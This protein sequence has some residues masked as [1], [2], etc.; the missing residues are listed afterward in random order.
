MCP[1]ITRR[2]RRFGRDEGSTAGAH[3]RSGG[4]RGKGAELTSAEATR[5]DIRSRMAGIEG[6]PSF[7]A[8]H[9]EITKLARSGEASRE[10]ITDKI[11]LDPILLATV[12]R[13]ANSAHFEFRKTIDSLL[14]AVTLLGL[15]EIANLVMSVQAFEKLGNHEGGAGLELEA[16]WKH[17]VGTAF[18]ARAIAR[19]L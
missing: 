3:R 4:S 19:R 13:L 12:F 8:T 15:E 9:T 2:I 18:V 6:L 16:F 11:Q 7:P 5:A 14:L 1:G 17:S 10:E